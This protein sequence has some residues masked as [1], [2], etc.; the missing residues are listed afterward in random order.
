[1]FTAL[2]RCLSAAL[3]AHARNQMFLESSCDFFVPCFSLWQCKV[4]S[5]ISIG[6]M[7]FADAMS[8]SQI[9]KTGH[10]DD[11]VQALMDMVIDQDPSDS[12]SDVAGFKIIDG[13]Q[14]F[15]SLRFFCVSLSLLVC[16]MK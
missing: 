10:R 13:A 12:A 9:M 2:V 4:F 3:S 6:E 14:G 15:S 16:L 7:A 1:M 8:C 11:A 5:P